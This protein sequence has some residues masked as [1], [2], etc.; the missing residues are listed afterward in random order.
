MEGSHGTMLSG[1]AGNP[2]LISPLTWKAPGSETGDRELAVCVGYGHGHPCHLGPTEG[3]CVD[4]NHL[5]TNGELIGQHHLGTN[6]GCVGQHP[7][8]EQLGTD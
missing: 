7:L 6:G 2:A 8:L 4:Q 3:G 5:G 1:S